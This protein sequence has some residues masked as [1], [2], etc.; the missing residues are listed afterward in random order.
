MGSRDVP[1][2]LRKSQISPE[3]GPL[4]ICETGEDKNLEFGMHV[5]HER[6]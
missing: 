2:E 1:L 5:D 3:G 4:R 6:R